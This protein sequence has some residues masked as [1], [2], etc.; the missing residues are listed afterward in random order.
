HIIL[1]GDL[2]KNGRRKGNKEFYDSGRFFTMTGDAIGGYIHIADDRDY[3][4]LNYLHNKYI[5]SSE[6]SAEKNKLSDNHGT[7]LSKDEIIQ[8]ATNSKNG[9]RFKLFLHGGWE[10]F[11]SSQSEA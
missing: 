11:Y 6:V 5:A 4:K 1:K 9:M 7:S 3:G 8:I 10:Q 2:P